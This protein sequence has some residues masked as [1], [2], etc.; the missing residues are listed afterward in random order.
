MRVTVGVSWVH[1]REVGCGPRA[2]SGNIHAH[3]NEGTRHLLRGSRE[4]VSQFCETM[5][6]MSRMR[7]GVLALSFSLLGALSGCCGGVHSHKC[8]FTPLDT[9]HDAAA[10][11]TLLCGSELCTDGKVCCVTVS[12]PA[13][14]C[15]VIEDFASLGCMLPPEQQVPCFSPGDCDAGQVCCLNET[16]AGSINCLSPVMCPGGGQ[17]GT[18][19]ACASAADCPGQAINACQPVPGVPKQGDASVLNYCDPTVK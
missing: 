18:Y 7:L 14:H 19:H 12:P 4:I 1:I 15:V 16:G 3:L 9:P 13:A 5:I 10:D 11:H 6:E 8:D 17:A 2:E